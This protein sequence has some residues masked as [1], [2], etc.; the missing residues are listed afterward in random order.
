MSLEAVPANPNDRERLRSELARFG[1]P[2]AAGPKGEAVRLSEGA[3][4]MA[5]IVRAL[6]AAGIAVAELLLHQP[7][8]DDV[9]LEKTGR[10]LEGAEAQD[11]DEAVA[12][13]R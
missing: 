11:E 6:D 1:T 10:S 12:G 9:F 4:Q 8:L 3:E 2:A 7:S 5:E 13:A